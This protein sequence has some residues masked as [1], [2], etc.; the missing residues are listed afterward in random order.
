MSDIH[1]SGTVPPEVQPVLAKL[2]GMS[3]QQ[4]E[5]RR[6]EIVASANGDYEQLT[7]LALQELCLITSTLRRRNAGPPK[8][9]KAAAK[10][11]S[12]DALLDF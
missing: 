12:L 8:E 11:K 2:E 6:R 9:P 3:P 1:T 5:L 7:D 4:L 10:P